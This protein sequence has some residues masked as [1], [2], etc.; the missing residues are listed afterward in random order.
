MLSSLHRLLDVRLMMRREV[1]PWRMRPIFRRVGVMFN[2][3]ALVFCAYGAS[4]LVSVQDSVPRAEHETPSALHVQPLAPTTTGG[5]LVSPGASDYAGEL[6]VDHGWCYVKW[7]APFASPPT[8]AIS[9][10]PGTNRVRRR[11]VRRA[12]RSVLL[13]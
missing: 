9:V 11:A 1:L 13:D 10:M 2:V 3:L 12:R 5:C 4:L 6:H 7:I 8:S